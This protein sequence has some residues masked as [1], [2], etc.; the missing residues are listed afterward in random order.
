[1]TRIGS[2]LAVSRV[3]FGESDGEEMSMKGDNVVLRA[4]LRVSRPSRL[5]G[6]P[7]VEAI[8]AFGL[9]GS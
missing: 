8:R 6:E 7:V 2:L 4:R 3:L 9:N 5:E 1:M